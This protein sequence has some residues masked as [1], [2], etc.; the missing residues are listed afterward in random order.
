MHMQKIKVKNYREI[1]CAECLRGAELDFDFS[2][3]FQPIVDVSMKTV[4]AQ[5]ALA[6]GIGDQPAGE[7]FKHVNDENRYAFDQACRVKAVYLASKLKIPSLLSINFMPNAVYRP[8]LCIRTTLA[9][10]K[11]FGFP[12]QRIMFE[13]TESERVGDVPH[14]HSIISHYK[15]QGF[16]TALDDF[17]AGF[18]G[19]NML[20]DLEVDTLKID[21]HLARDIDTHERKQAIVKGIVSTCTD[22]GIKVIAEGVETHNEF[23]TLRS[24]GIDLF[25]GYFFAR[26]SYEALADIAWDNVM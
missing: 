2:M 6:R 4:F 7:V 14:L 16:L 1:G 5:E 21:M 10:A 12:L 15:E 20:A 23:K 26:P 8:E 17:G 11:E 19:L 3:A 9:A 25:Q 18:S 22:L 13:V 24:L